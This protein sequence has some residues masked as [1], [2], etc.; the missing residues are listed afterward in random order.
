VLNDAT[1][2]EP[3]AGMTDETYRR[4]YEGI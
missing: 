3:A 1:E 2:A 4:S